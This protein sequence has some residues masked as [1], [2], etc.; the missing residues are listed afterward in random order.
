MID[1]D[2][3]DLD[4]ALSHSRDG[5]FHQAVQ[6]F[7]ESALLDVRAQLQ[8]GLSP[9]DFERARR[10]E[11]AILKAGDVVRFSAES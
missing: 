9:L 3:P 4:H 8:R 10:I 2:T 11:A 5:A 1:I 7:L 6:H